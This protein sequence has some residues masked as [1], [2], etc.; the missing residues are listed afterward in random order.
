MNKRKISLIFGTGLLT[1]SLTGCQK[2]NEVTVEVEGHGPVIENTAD[3]EELE[4]P[5]VDYSSGEELYEATGIDLANET[6]VLETLENNP[7]DAIFWEKVGDEIAQIILEYDDGSA[8]TFRAS[9]TLSGLQNLAGVYG[10][11][12]GTEMEGNGGM[13]YIIEEGTSV[14]V[15]SENGI[16]YSIKTEGPRDSTIQPR[17]ADSDYDDVA[18][19]A[20]EYASSLGYTVA[21]DAIKAM[22]NAYATFDG[23]NDDSIKDW[24][25]IAIK[26]C[27][28]R[29]EKDSSAE[30]KVII[31]ED[32]AIGV[33]K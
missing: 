21:D 29:V 24:I 1:L 14:E 26:N 20:N 22:Q 3:N 13:S 23:Y 30:A 9:K 19:V 8:K 33:A 11:Y 4:N 32:L 15:Y 7:T 2:K 6:V 5:V 28:A 25:D 16:N 18:T 10:D 27:D 31:A 17:N 12:A